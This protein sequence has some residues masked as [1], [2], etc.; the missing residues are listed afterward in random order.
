M[1]TQTC[2]AVCNDGYAGSNLQLTCAADSGAATASFNISAASCAAAT[3]ADPTLPT[4]VSIGD[5]NGKT[6]GQTCN[7]VCTDTNMVGTGLSVTCTAASGAAT[8][9]ID[10][11]G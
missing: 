3:C 4:G 2:N 5:C 9:A 8:A 11:S 10:A 6:T 7:L 1:G